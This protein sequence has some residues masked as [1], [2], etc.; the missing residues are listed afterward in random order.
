MTTCVLDTSVAAKWYLPS[1]GEPLVPE[2]VNLA[3]EFAAGRLTMFAPDLLWPELG[4]VLW[5]AAKL[6]RMPA[7]SARECIRTFAQLGIATVSSKPLVETAFEIGRQFQCTVYDG[8]YVALAV[9][10]NAPLVTADER[11]VNGLASRFPVRWLGAL[12]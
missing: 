5:K 3:R 2:A 9:S 7:A 4:N 12:S 10:L 1:A 8:L 6:G 11:L